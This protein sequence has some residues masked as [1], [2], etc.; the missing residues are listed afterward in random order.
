MMDNPAPE[1]AFDGNAVG[2]GIIA[3]NGVVFAIQLANMVLLKMKF[4]DRSKKVA[5]KMHRAL[6]GTRVIPVGQTDAR[7]DGETGAKR[8][9]ART[10][11]KDTPAPAIEDRAARAWE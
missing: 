2:V 8:I 6:T 4:W 5:R 3:M 11:T 1:N 10:S 9:A 7:K